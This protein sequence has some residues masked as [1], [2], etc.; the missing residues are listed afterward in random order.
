MRRIT[1]LLALVAVCSLG[2]SAA[3]ACPKH[4]A[5][6]KK[7][8]AQETKLIKSACSAK[9]VCA[10][11]DKFP[12]LVQLVGDKQ[13]GCPTEAAKLAKANGD[14][15]IYA[16]GSDKFECRQTAATAWAEASE[17]YAKRFVTIACV[18]DGKVIY[19]DEPCSD[20]SACCSAKAKLSKAD[21]KGCSKAGATKAKLVKADGK[22]SCSSLTKRANSAEKT[23]SGGK[24]KLAS[25]DGKTCS[26]ASKAKLAKADGKGCCS[27]SKTKITK[28][29]GKG[30]CSASKAKLAKAEGKG[31]CSASKAKLAKADDK[32][33]KKT[34]KFE[35]TKLA[36]AEGKGSC[37]ASKAKLA[38]TDGKGSCKAGAK[39]TKIVSAEGKGCCSASKTKLAKN[40][41]YRVVGRDFDTWTAAAKARDQASAAA[42][43]VS[44]KYIVDGKEVAC[45]SQVCP[46]AK[47]DG[48]VVYVISGEKMEC[49]YSARVA[50]AKAQ[51][52]A[53]KA[54]CSELLAKL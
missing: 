36:K 16:V 28:A 3:Q 53:A 50:L 6:N 39:R 38:K 29:E 11:A 51:C 15:I 41:K 31:S 27:A 34:C 43:K 14:K 40:V 13:V 23:C 8:S 7:A 49:Q 35:A 21:G 30:S 19:C 17:S 24:A 5:A 54:A 22:A 32:S 2:I 46:K 9:T 45:A 48:K 44:M 25:A 33:S 52:Q 1:T 42:K 47:A 4:E 20:A 10:S 18:I 12:T 26:S 37:S